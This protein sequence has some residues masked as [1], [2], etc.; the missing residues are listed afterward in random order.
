MN[1]T[2][3]TS[4]LLAFDTNNA[5]GVNHFHIQILHGEN[6]STH[7]VTT[8]NIYA[9]Q[10]GKMLVKM[11]YTVRISHIGTSTDFGPVVKPKGAK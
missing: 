11:G 7:S 6:W 10:I 8:L 4:K 9:E 2:T 3:D 1:A 5:T